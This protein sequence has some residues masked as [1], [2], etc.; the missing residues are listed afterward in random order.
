VVD[1]DGALLPEVREIADL[2]REHDAVLA[3]GHTS[4]VEHLA[5]ARE[6]GR[7]Q[8]VLV[9]H[10]MEELAGPNLG[11]DECAELAELGATIELCAL[12]CIGAL[13]TRPVTDL[14]GAAQRIGA[15]RCT[16]ASDYGQAVNEP[17]AEGLQRFVDALVSEGVAVADIRAMVVTNPAVLVAT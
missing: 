9:T 4:A 8:K 14:V 11:V 2:C 17:P 6:Y 10:A 16:L 5:V 12:T 1:G 15:D 7:R 13:A 3:T